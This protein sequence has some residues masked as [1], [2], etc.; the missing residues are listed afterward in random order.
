MNHIIIYLSSNSVDK[1][2]EKMDT[3]MTIMPLA[4]C[5]EPTFFIV[6]PYRFLV[7]IDVDPTMLSRVIRFM[8]I[9]DIQITTGFVLCWKHEQQWNWPAVFVFTA[10]KSLMMREFCRPNRLSS[11]VPLPLTVMTLPSAGGDIIASSTSSTSSTNCPQ[12]C[13]HNQGNK[14]LFAVVCSSPRSASKLDLLDRIPKMKKEAWPRTF[15]PN[16]LK[17]S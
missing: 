2:P 7:I 10:L 16:T 14:C 5:S 6:Q 1:Y 13:S 3:G 4:K 15:N 9:N 11:N 17:M 8:N 12:I